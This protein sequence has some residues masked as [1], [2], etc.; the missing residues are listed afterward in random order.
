M[1]NDSIRFWQEWQQQFE[2]DLL[3]LEN[4]LTQ[5]TNASKNQATEYRAE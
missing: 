5:K 2:Q 4:E 1:E 3:E